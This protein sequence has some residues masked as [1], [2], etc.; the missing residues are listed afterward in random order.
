MSF[1]GRLHIDEDPLRVLGPGER[2]RTRM[3]PGQGLVVIAVSAL[4]SP[5]VEPG[6]GR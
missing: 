5:D 4:V 2:H 6:L 3:H 1:E